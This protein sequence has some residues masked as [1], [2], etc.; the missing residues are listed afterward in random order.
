MIGKLRA[1]ALSSVV[2]EENG[3]E[4]RDGAERRSRE[5]VYSRLLARS[6]ETRNFCWRSGDR[7]PAN[8][9]SACLCVRARCVCVLACERERKYTYTERVQPCV[10]P[11]GDRSRA[12][13]GGVCARHLRASRIHAEEFYYGPLSRH[14]RWN[15]I[16][17]AA[18]LRTRR[19]SPLSHSSIIC[20]YFRCE[21]VFDNF[22]YDECVE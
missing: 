20:I 16:G 9:L 12:E 4:R 17:R 10:R 14:T 6:L 3:R 21:W 19:S 18:F 8:T 22:M 5:A 11:L 1:A 7:V 15:L 13:G 2:V